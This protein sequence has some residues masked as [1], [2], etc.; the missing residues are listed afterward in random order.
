MKCEDCEH[1][2]PCY[3]G[4]LFDNGLP[5]L[6]PRCGRLF[7]WAHW[8][9][10]SGFACELRKVLPEWRSGYEGDSRSARM[11]FTVN[12]PGPTGGKIQIT[13]CV[14]CREKGAPLRATIGDILKEKGY[15]V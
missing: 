14:N 15:D 5:Q 3:N 2:L 8:T 12:D 11:S 1:T 9:S 7:L 10:H 13:A 4:K 6:C